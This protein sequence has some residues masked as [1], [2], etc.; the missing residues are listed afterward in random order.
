MTIPVINMPQHFQRCLRQGQRPKKG[1]RLQFVRA[2]VDGMRVH[3]ANPDL[4]ACSTVAHRIYSQYPASFEDQL[5]GE[6]LGSGYAFLTNQLK[7]RI[8]HV[9]RGDL[10]ARLRCPRRLALGSSPDA[11]FVTQSPKDSFGCISYAP[12]LPVDQT[13]ESQELKRVQLLELFTTHGPGAAADGIVVQTMEETYYAQRYDVTSDVPTDELIK[14]W[15]WLFVERHF[16]SHFKTLTGRDALEKVAHSVERTGILLVKFFLSKGDRAKPSVRDLLPSLQASPNNAVQVI[17]ML[18]A[19][20][21]EKEIGL[22]RLV[23]V[24]AILSACNFTLTV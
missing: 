21:G 7:S 22:F 14:R 16:L 6:R 18:A 3:C 1:L 8:E 12:P 5:N 2:V 17:R 24:S 15:P 20:F 11:S 19:A 13:E 10:D 9:T 23:N 4:H